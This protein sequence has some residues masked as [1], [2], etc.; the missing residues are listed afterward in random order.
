LAIIWRASLP[1]NGYDLL[2]TADEPEI[3]KAARDFQSTGALRGT[4]VGLIE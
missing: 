2:I 4:Q 1:K 3:E